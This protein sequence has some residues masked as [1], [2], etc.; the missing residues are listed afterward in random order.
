M[1]NVERDEKGRLLPGAMANPKGRPRGVPNKL[2]TEVRQMVRE[3]LEAEGGVD[4]LRWAS[5]KQPVAFLALCGKLIP[6]EIRASLGTEG[7]MLVEVRDYAGFGARMAR[8]E[9]IPEPR[10]LGAG[11]GGPREHDPDAVVGP[12]SESPEGES[13]TPATVR[14][15]F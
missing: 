4:Y 13:E 12:R 6:S 2:T 10:L 1:E 11:N 5:R 3:A 15:E 8:G 9:K 7:L 14:I